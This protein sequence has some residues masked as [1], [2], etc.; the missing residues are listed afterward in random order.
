M[1]DNQ[2]P[3]LPSDSNDSDSTGEK[4]P[5]VDA[6]AEEHSDNQDS[7]ET[8]ALAKPE[9]RDQSVS[10]QG[11]RNDKTTQSVSNQGARNDKTTQSVSNQ[12]ARNDKT[13][14][15]V[16]NQ[17]A[18]NDKTTQSAQERP[19]TA[20][21][22]RRE[23]TCP[24]CGNTY[25]TSTEGCPLCGWGAARRQRS[26]ERTSWFGILAAGLNVRFVSNSA[27][28]MLTLLIEINIVLTVAGV[29]VLLATG[30]VPILLLMSLVAA[31][32]LAHSHCQMFSGVLKSSACGFDQVNSEDK[33]HGLLF[34]LLS[35]VL[36]A[37]QVGPVAA[38]AVYGIRH[39]WEQQEVLWAVALGGVSI[40]ALTNFSVMYLLRATL[41]SPLRNALNPI[42][43]L[44]WA[45]RCPFSLTSTLVASG[46][47]NVIIAAV[48]VAF[49]ALTFTGATLLIEGDWDELNQLEEILTES[50]PEFA[51]DVSNA[52]P[53]ELPTSW[54]RIERTARAVIEHPE[55]I[56]PALERILERVRV[57]E[58]RWVLAVAGLVVH[59]MWT[60][61]QFHAHFTLARMLGLFA[62]RYQSRLGWTEN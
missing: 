10:N 51:E 36:I 25:E 7:V 42:R 9:A 31:I 19:P 18:R 54:S 55:I 27:A 5:D 22:K 53:D 11:A 13:T 35:S 33:R 23:R 2:D 12:G 20:I 17:G 32:Y 61:F 37:L 38:L 41:T 34:F 26:L 39:L 52:A 24:T 62:R 14:Q 59:V 29:L 8:Y 6:N 49:A 44:G 30:S 43:A 15:S 58:N 4:K 48:A 45:V 1:N 56:R 60:Y 16:S 3:S 57:S 46:L 28:S 47:W 40:V 21:P 50:V